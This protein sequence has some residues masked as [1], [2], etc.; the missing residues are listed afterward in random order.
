M[1]RARPRSED[2]AVRGACTGWRMAEG[3]GY[4]LAD[5]VAKADVAHTASSDG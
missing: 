5:A 3:T 2:L 1:G 4:A